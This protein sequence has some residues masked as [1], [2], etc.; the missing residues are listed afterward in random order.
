MQS[1][2]SE[3]ICFPLTNVSL[4]EFFKHGNPRR[5]AKL[6]FVMTWLSRGI[7]IADKKTRLQREIMVALVKVLGLPISKLD[8]QIIVRGL[9][10]AIIS[11]EHFRRVLNWSMQ[12]TQKILEEVDN[13][14]GMVDFFNSV[15]DE[16]RIPLIDQL[17]QMSLA[18]ARGFE[19]HRSQYK[20]LH[21]T[22]LL[23]VI[24]AQL[25]S[26]TQDEFVHV[27]NGLHI[28]KDIIKQLDMVAVSSE[29]PSY[30][31][32][33]HLRVESIRQYS[34]K[35]AGNDSYDIE[36]MVAAL[37]YCSAAV[38]EAFWVDLCRRHGFDRKYN[39]ELHTNYKDMIKSM[40]KKVSS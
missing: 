30:N 10:R 16:T 7:V 23:R 21:P 9:T 35:V 25:F 40:K 26:S 12:K 2:A 4:L 14:E 8:M 17:R 27:L 37:P 38:T 39:C 15:T 13:I 11:D 6:G 5:R 20:K 3:E 18:E 1:V 33:A 31:I 36:G 32:E 29:I 22:E 24:Y 34:R 19:E 28:P